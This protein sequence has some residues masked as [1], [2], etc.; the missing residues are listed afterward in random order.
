MSSTLFYVKEKFQ[1]SLGIEP[2]TFGV[3]VGNA[4]HYNIQAAEIY[5]PL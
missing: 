4:N 3:A 2:S 5:I 1:A